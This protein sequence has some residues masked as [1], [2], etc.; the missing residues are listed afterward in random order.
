MRIV[1]NGYYGAGNIGDELILTALLRQIR[2]IDATS[3]VTVLGFCPSETAQ[4]HNVKAIY[5][6]SPGPEWVQTPW[7]TI[8]HAVKCADLIIIGGG[9]L[10]EDIH[11]FGSIPMHLQIAALGLM[12]GKPVVGLG[13]GVGP[14]IT[15]LSQLLV[16]LIARHMTL[17]VVRDSWS[18]SVLSGI[19]VSAEKIKTSTDIAF[20]MAADE[21]Q[22][23]RPPKRHPKIGVIAGPSDWLN[24]RWSEIALGVNLAAQQ[25]SASQVVLFPTGKNPRDMEV[26]QKISDH[27]TVPHQIK[28]APETPKDLLA[29]AR[30]F[31]VIVSTKLHGIIAAACVG[32]PV[33]AISY[34]PKV[35]SIAQQL[36]IPSRNINKIEAS[37]LAGDI[38]NALQLRVYHER[39]RQLTAMAEDSVRQAVAEG[40][41]KGHHRP[42][43][44]MLRD[45][46]AFSFL[47]PFSLAR[48]IRR[49]KQ[50][51]ANWAALQSLPNLHNTGA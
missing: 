39:I 3:D 43:Y 40:L 46:L 35:T 23:P 15:P 4:L 48:Q 11:H 2:Q 45:L 25:T 6:G 34:A 14:I 30:D 17:I 49:S 42:D 37:Q 19:G 20:A 32:T 5:R 9:G 21:T 51:N 44:H 47:T 18:A 36:G 29:T 16:R 8:I 33:T 27:L 22:M 24:I 1:I 13:L 12:L 7:H 31:D 41:T 28:S 38:K 10:L 50:G 26:L